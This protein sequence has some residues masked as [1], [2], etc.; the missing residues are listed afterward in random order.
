M[1][2]TPKD[3]K[4]LETVINEED[5]LLFRYCATNKLSVNLT[6]TNFMIISSRSNKHQISIL[7]IKR[8]EYLTYLGIYLDNTI[9][10]TQQITHIKNKVTK[11]SVY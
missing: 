1:L 9:K 11:K 8:K 7:N 4:E 2:S 6:K 5:E 3:V 10:W